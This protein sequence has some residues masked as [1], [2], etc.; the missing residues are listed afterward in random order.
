MQ[1][2]KS[3]LLNNF[4]NLTHAFTTREG[5]VSQKPYDSLNLAWHV[6]DE[7][8]HVEMNHE[9]LAKELEY[10]KNSLVHMKQ[11][12]SNLVHIV[13]EEDNFHMPRSC[14]A[15]IT[16]KPNTP[17]MVMVA[18]C[19]PILFYDDVQ[20]VIAVAHAGRAGAFSNIIKNV[21]NSFVDEFHSKPE[22]I[23]VSIGTS[24]GRCCYEVGDEIYEV[25]CG[26]GFAFAMSQKNERWY[27]DVG[28]I[29]QSQLLAC[30]IQKE[31]LESSSECTCC[32]NETYFSYRAD[33]ITGRFAGVIEMKN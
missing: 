21:I 15:L 2:I 6:E 22:N 11:I 18:D 19:S 13:N 16:N 17:L 24:I 27:L 20:K 26:N 9:L 31:H 29:L 25:A 4:P 32:K 28:A 10:E 30:G 3:T 5:G 7:T 12:H 1:L 8:R 33:G 14:D 23:F